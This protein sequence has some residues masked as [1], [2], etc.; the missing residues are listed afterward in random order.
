MSAAHTPLATARPN[1]AHTLIAELRSIVGRKHTLTDDAAT[2][3]FRT[4][5]RFGAGKALAVVRPGTIVEQWKVLQACVAANVIVI[6]QASNTGLTGGSTPDGDDYDRDIVIVSTS[7]MKKV[8]VIDG[9]KQVVCLP[10]ATLDQLERTLKPLGRE[11]HSVIGSSCIGAS[12]FG[13]VCNNS[14][15]AL[16]QRGPAYT[17]MAA[18]AQVDETGK[19]QFVNHLGIRLG[20]TPEDMLGRLER[21]EFSDSDVQHNAGAGSDHG[22]ARHVREVDADTPARFNADP[23]RLHEASGSAGKLMVFAVR[24]DTFPIEQNAKVFYIGTNQPDELTEIRR[25]ALHDFKFLPI[26]GEYLHRDAFDV[27]EEYGKD[28]FLAINYLGTSRLPALFGLKSRCDA[29]FDRLGFLPSHFADRVMQAASRL[30]PSHLPVRMKQYRDKYEHHLMLKVAAESVGETRAFLS[31]Y[32]GNA[33]GAY[34]ECTDEE[35]RKAFLHRFAAAGAAVRYRAVHTREVENIV[36][37]DIALR[38]N[39]RDWIETLPPEIEETI[40]IKLYYGHFLCHVF[41]QD[42][43]VRK[44]NDCLEVEHKM[45][46]LLDR[47]GAEYPAEHNVGHLYHAK[48]QLAAFYRQLDPCNCFNPGIGQTSK[49]RNYRETAV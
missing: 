21:G 24:L 28:T 27:A 25:H 19:L 41:H 36:A 46:T 38:R 39:D 45:W 11:P 9:G 22:Y 26:S 16:V 6:T 34:F 35:G 29:L 44:G 43:I 7:R 2:R 3:S 23:Q 42:Y 49:F 17:E 30:F 1:V 15:G 18:F 37:L 31:A 12:V 13:G 14:G 10:G 48:P 8:F 32:F 4:G 40:A 5:F 47:R 20:E 33:T